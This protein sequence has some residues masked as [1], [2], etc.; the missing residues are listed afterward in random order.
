MP[1]RVA[2]L[3]G[4]R[5]LAILAVLCGH[6]AGIEL[7][8][9]GRFGV[10]LFFV[11][12]GRLMAEILFVRRTPIG[13]FFFRRF[14]RVWPTLFGF[15][16]IATVVL[17][18]TPLALRPVESVQALTFTTN[19]FGA[20][21]HRAAALDHVWSLC[22]EEHSYL[23][24][25]VLALCLRRWGGRPGTVLMAVAALAMANG[26]VMSLLGG[27]YYSVYWRTDVRA[28]S[29]FAGAGLFLLLRG[30]ALN[31]YF[32]VAC[33]ALALLLGF[34]VV[35]DPLKYSIGTA[36]LAAAMATLDRAPKWVLE[37]LSWKPLTTLG[38]LSYSLYLWQQPFYRF[39]A[40]DLAPKPVLFAG[41]LLVG[42][43]SY[44]VLEQPARIALTKRIKRGSPGSSV[45]P[46]A[47]DAPSLVISPGTEPERTPGSPVL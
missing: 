30:R 25:G 7:F 9:A 45:P 18:W 5:G 12:S 43:I 44:Y 19:Y 32:P 26:I 8:N 23:V 42:C 35:P 22:V 3:D 21:G 10:E 4:W 20:Y 27:N 13:E 46:P 31:P 17:W 2:Y 34:D 24:L 37:P 41:A 1:P 40:I 6:F 16:L 39:D 38:M 15:I 29:I 47:S 28:G 33:G 11:L 14:A 36:C